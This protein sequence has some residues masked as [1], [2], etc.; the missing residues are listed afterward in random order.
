MDSVTFKVFYLLLMLMKSTDLFMEPVSFY[1]GYL[2][3]T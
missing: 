2:T 1:H 3:L